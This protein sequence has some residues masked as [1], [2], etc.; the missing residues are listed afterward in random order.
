MAPALVWR[1]LWIGPRVSGGV[2]AER[3]GPT[4]GALTIEYVMLRFAFTW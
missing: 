4:E 3:D 2:L 1:W